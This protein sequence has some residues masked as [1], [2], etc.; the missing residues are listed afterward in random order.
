MATQIQFR[1]GTK[2][3]HN[4]FTGADGEVTVDTTNLSLHVHDG[5]TAGGFESARADLSNH[6][7]VGILTAT[8]FDGNLIGNVTGT[9]SSISNHDTGD[10][11]EGSNLYYTD[12]R[13]RSAISV[14]DSGG[15]GSLSYNSGTGVITYTGPSASEVRAHFSAGTGVGISS[16]QI[17]IGQPV[18]T[19]SN[20]TFNDVVI[21]NNATV[22]GGLTVTGNL[23][24]NGTTTTINSTTISVDDKNIELGSTTSPS[25]AS[26][27]GGGITLK[28]TTDHTINW[29]NT[30]DSWDFS[31]HVN[32]IT[33][34]EYRIA[35]TSVLS[36]T[37]LGSSV[38]NSSLTS[39]GTIASGTWQGTPI[40]NTYLANSTI[41]GVSLG[42]NLNTLTMGVSGT[43]LSGSQTYNG[44]GAATFTVTSNATSNN[45]NSTIVAR[46]ASGNFSA[47]T[48]TASLN[49]NAGTATTTTNIPNLSGDIT[50]TN[51]TTTL[52]TVNSNIGT[53]GS[54]SSIPTITVNGKGLITAVSTT[55]VDPAN[56]G[57][58]TLA[59]SGTGLSGSATFTANQSG[60]S[61][62]TVTSNATSNNTNSTIVARDAS[63]NF[64]AGTITASLNGNA[65]TATSLSTAR[66]IAL[67]GDV[68]GSANF[69]GSAGITITA[70]IAANSVALGSDTT[71]NYVAAGAVSGNGLSGSSSSEGGTFTVS[72][73]A[74]E[75]NTGSTIVF[76]DASGNFNAGIVTASSFSGPLTGNVTG[77]VTGA[78]TGN[79]ATATKL[80]TARSIGLGGDVS[81]SASF[82]GSAGITITATVAD[83]SHN[84]V[85]SNVDGLQT[86][87][88]L[89][90]PLASPALSG[91][92]TAP[93]AAAGTN[94]TQVATT[95]FVSTAVANLVDTAP[96]A[97]D[98]LN[99]LAAALGD[100]PNFATTVSTSIGTK[101]DSA[102]YN[103]ADVLTKI[104][105]VDG[106]SSGLDADLLD[107]QE[108][109]YYRNA[110]NINA[111]TI[112]DAYLP[113]TISSDI[114]G[115]AGTATNATNSTNVAITNNTATNASYYIHFGSAT[116][117]NDG[118]EVD[119][120]GLTYN[121]SS[122]TLTTGT[123]SGALS[124]NSSTATKLAT[125]RTIALSGDVTGSASFDGSANATISATIAANSVALGTDTT[126]NYVASISNGSY[127]TG[128]NGG[129]EGA[130]LTLAV[131]ATSA[132]TAS[133]VVARDSSG[134]FSAGTIT[135]SLSGNAT[136]ATTATTA[137]SCSG[138]AAT[139]TILQTARSIN[140][141]SF[142]GSANI[143][144]E[145]YIEDDETTNA[146]RYIT[147]V[148]NTTAAFKR[149][150]EDSSLTYNPS[151]NTV[152]AGTFSG[153]LSGNSSTATKLATARSIG[154][155]GDVS[156]SANFDGSANITITATV[157]NDS[158]THDG[159]Y[160]TESESDTRFLQRG[161]NSWH[162]SSDGRQRLYFTNVSHTYLKSSD[163][164]YFRTENSDTDNCY[165]AS[166]SITC[167]NLNSTSDINLKKD[168]EVISDANDILSQI[169]GIRFSWKSDGKKC[170]GV[171]AQ[172]VEKVLP[173]LVVESENEQKTKTVNYQGLIGVLIEAVK[174]QQKQINLLKE[175]IELLKQ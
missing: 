81:G 36:A 24:V 168:I 158:H 63:G 70:T 121:P 64:S 105:T 159:R 97:L 22:G 139:A 149:L 110:S 68:S 11:T 174:D 61:T 172:E 48:I 5:I 156:G 4:A 161:V 45:T 85:I 71:G 148:D 37:T 20:V 171:I 62:F 28:G 65:G 16:G 79:A 30:N 144:I 100:D 92:P 17:S 52:A 175:E 118:V 75:T 125:A 23:V 120:T 59:T 163:N 170:V 90:A 135:A 169:N 143:T 126:G 39:V 46:D 123:F 2:V 82:D 145:S 76:R 109:S 42:S 55:A 88:D 33:G 124:G 66:A 138:N 113:A 35:N 141:V 43:G 112:G 1:R 18:A 165:I 54:G 147:F 117:G 83:D 3:Q 94:T 60:I 132:N 122:N 8:T 9:V 13:A 107:G 27:D 160:Y 104:K 86:A 133:K 14:T 26:A 131:D 6:S 56:D 103:A 102:D 53:F 78:L 116:S 155:G 84:H 58:L 136:S 19:N 95:A 101:L 154:L 49:G 15:D 91:T 21:S 134:N 153:A 150:N 137:G 57:T 99:E 142:N 167:V 31:E 108:G 98:T 29:S 111:G 87:L 40:A 32:I 127:I 74:T 157:A 152:T 50:S 10:L 93:T 128:A 151:T 51:T 173:E 129:S 67:S 106:A 115:N 164:I 72:S 77:N 12:V 114:T 41:S 89:K 119:S 140:G 162:T 96:A 166:G 69:D 73:N 130:G 44:S 80:A 7:N 146:T 25:D 34:K 47:G 38:V